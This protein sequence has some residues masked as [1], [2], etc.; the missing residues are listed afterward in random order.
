M[1]PDREGTVA[2]LGQLLW[3]HAQEAYRVQAAVGDQLGLHVTDLACLNTLSTQQRT[4][5]GELADRLGVTTGAVTRMTDRLAE[6]GY[7]RRSADPADRRRVL[8]ELTAAAVAEV[9]PAY[10][11]VSRDLAATVAACTDEQIQFLMDFLRQRIVSSRRMTAHLRG[12]RRDEP[13]QRSRVS[14]T[15]TP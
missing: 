5:A 14:T 13:D 11:E 3:W 1:T 7:V 9:G 8:I 15:S 4:T 12:Q 10:Q 6:R 2:E